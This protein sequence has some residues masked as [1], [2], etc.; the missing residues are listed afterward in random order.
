MLDIVEL[1]FAGYGD[2]H[3]GWV[4]VA[5][6]RY[7]HL[8]IFHAQLYTSSVVVAK[9]PYGSHNADCLRLR[10]GYALPYNG[11]SALFRSLDHFDVSRVVLVYSV[12]VFD[13][14]TATS[15]GQQRPTYTWRR[16]G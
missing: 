13:K 16:V 11:Q 7:V 4:E 12:R 15:G 9:R 6:V 14:R 10:I 2:R 3:L 5:R 1:E 8:V